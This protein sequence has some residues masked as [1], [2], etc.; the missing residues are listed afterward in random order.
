MGKSRETM[1]KQIVFK[2]DTYGKQFHSY[3]SVH[4]PDLWDFFPPDFNVIMHV[5]NWLQAQIYS[6]QK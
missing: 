6:C 1:T 2:V 3:F 5:L 4:T